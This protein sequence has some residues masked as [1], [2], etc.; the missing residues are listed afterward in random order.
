MTTIAEKIQIAADI[1]HDE[2][3]K[4]GTVIS[5][6]DALGLARRLYDIWH[7]QVAVCTLP[8]GDVAKR[9]RERYHD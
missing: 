5:P 1:I 2:V 7:E 4:A 8:P 6:A 9:F 3:Q